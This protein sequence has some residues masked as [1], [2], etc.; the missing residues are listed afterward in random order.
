M[1]PQTAFTL[2]VKETSVPTVFFRTALLCMTAIGA[3]ACAE[4]RDFPETSVP[5]A[6]QQQPNSKPPVLSIVTDLTAAPNAQS[7][8]RSLLVSRKAE[9]GPSDDVL[10]FYEE[11]R[12]Q[13]AWSGGVMNEQMAR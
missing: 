9:R 2:L 5:I 11:R 8:L 6:I 13:P 1:V 4:T 3:T 7:A 10:A 12:L